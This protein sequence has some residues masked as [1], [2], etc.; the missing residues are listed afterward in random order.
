MTG[1]ILLSNSIKFI[2]IKT[3]TKLNLLSTAFKSF[4]FRLVEQFQQAK[5]HPAGEAF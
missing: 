4:F 2:I 3:N 5:Q 1:L